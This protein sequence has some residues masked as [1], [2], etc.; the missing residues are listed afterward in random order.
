[1]NKYILTST[2]ILYS[3][4]FGGCQQNKT[5]LLKDDFLDTKVGTIE[6]QK[7]VQ[8]KKIIKPKVVE[9]I[10]QKP[11]KI[12]KK[13]RVPSISVQEKKQHFKD[14]LVPIVTSVYL[15]LNNQYEDVKRDI[16]GNINSEFITKLKKRYRVQSDELLL[17]ALKPHPVSI[18]LAQSAIE[19]AWLTSRFTK[20]ANNIFGVWSFKKD[21]P[22]IAATGLR[23]DKTIYLR[24]YKTLKQAVEHYYYNLS[25]SRAY[26]SFRST[27]VESNDPY[28]I[29]EH[30][31]AYSEKG[32]EYTDMLKRVISYNKFDEYDIR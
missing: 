24:K 19:S 21:E 11:K 18:A 12:V 9:K 3:I 16:E 32:T 4:S 22:R 28:I 8:K 29:V 30:L 31:Q 14:I 1:M 27:R 23:G 6:K 25:I 26:K 13:K 2:L 17:Q 20:Q 5:T 15:K 7:L 10:K